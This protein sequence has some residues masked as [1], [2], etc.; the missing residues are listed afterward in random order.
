MVN[1]MENKQE[2]FKRIASNR[3]NKIID[4]IRSLG[5]LTNSS[6]YEYTDEQVESMFAAI[7]AEIDN[8]KKVFESKKEKKQRKFE[9]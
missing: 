1:T 2:N 6:F 9:L 5:N 7:E 3:T 4:T 8:Q